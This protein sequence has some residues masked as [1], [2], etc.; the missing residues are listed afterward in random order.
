MRLFMVRAPGHGFVMVCTGLNAQILSRAFLGRSQPIAQAAT[1]R[2]STTI[3]VSWAAT[4]WRPA[5]IALR[6]PPSSRASLSKNSVPSTA[7]PSEAPS[8]WSDSS[9]PLALPTSR[10]SISPHDDAEQWHED[11][12]HAEPEDAEP[13]AECADAD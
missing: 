10:S 3:S 13:G 7:T 6:G 5:A 12:P 4:R 8:C 1:T 11:H 2:T 9:N